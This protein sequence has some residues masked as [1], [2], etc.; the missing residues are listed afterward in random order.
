MCME[1][2]VAN[3]ILLCSLK[4]ISLLWNIFTRTWAIFSH[5]CSFSPFYFGPL[6]CPSFI[7][8]ITHVSFYNK[9]WEKYY[10]ELGAFILMKPSKHFFSSPSVGAEHFEVNEKHVFVYFQYRSSTYMWRVR[11]FDLRSMINLSTRVNKTWQNSTKSKHFVRKIFN[12]T[13]IWLW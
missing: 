4:Y 5:F 7:F 2:L 8:C 3:L 1:Y 9:F 10:Q 13:N 6:L 12:E 11:D